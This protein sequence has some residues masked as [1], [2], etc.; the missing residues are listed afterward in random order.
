[1]LKSPVSRLI[2][3]ALVAGLLAFGAI[4]QQAPTGHL[5]QSVIGAALV[6]GILA[7][8]EVL[9]PLN[10]QVGVTFKQAEPTP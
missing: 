3:R 6:A 4:L 1:M 9:T 10:Q 8:L 5:D 2:G 7:G